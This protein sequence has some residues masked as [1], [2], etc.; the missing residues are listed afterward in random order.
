M[1]SRASLS[2]SS[3]RRSQ[4]AAAAS[5]SAGVT[6]RP[7]AAE[8]D[9]VEFPGQLDQRAL[10]ARR[11]VGDDRA[12]RLLDVRRR[13]ALGV[14]KRGNCAAKSAERASRR[15]GIARCPAG[16]SP[17]FTGQ[18]PA[19]EA[20]QPCLDASTGRRPGRHRAW[21]GRPSVPGR[22]EIGQLAFEALDLEPQRR[23]AGEDQRDGAG[24]RSV[25]SNSTASRFSTGS[26]ATGRAIAALAGRHPLEAQRGAAAAELRR[27][28]WPPPSRT[29]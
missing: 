25:S 18:W 27:D 5:S 26:L 24:G 12:H 22:A 14:E 7:M 20:R 17:G 13:L 15:I 11:H 23:A 3:A 16:I 28:L 10:A 19:P 21:A 2:A 1:R 4:A 8:I 29:G 6:R 9:A